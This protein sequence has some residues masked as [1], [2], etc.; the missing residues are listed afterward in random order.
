[1]ALGIVLP[2]LAVGVFAILLYAMIADLAPALGLL[3]FFGSGVAVC[4]GMSAIAAARRPMRPVEGEGRGYQRLE[5]R[6]LRP[7]RKVGF[8]A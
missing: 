4:A 1:M 5:R 6:A 7:R 8:R 3:I 2:A